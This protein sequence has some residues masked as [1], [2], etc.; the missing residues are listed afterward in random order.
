MLGGIIGCKDKT[1]WH[2]IGFPDGRNIIGW[3]SRQNHVEEKPTVIYCTRTLI[4]MQGWY[5]SV[6]NYGVP[7]TVEINKTF[8]LRL[9]F[10]AHVNSFN[11]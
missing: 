7:I 4:A 11:L 2:L 9:V 5:I 3:V 6:S 1:S 8:I 10:F